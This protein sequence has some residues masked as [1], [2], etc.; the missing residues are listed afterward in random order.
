MENGR[1][2]GYIARITRH[3]NYLNYLNFFFVRIKYLYISVIYKRIPF[4]QLCN[5]QP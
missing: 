2:N 1:T 5:K 3:L 4:F